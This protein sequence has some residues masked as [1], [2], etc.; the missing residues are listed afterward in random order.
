M[1]ISFEVLS[2]F[3]GNHHMFRTMLHS[4][5]TYREKCLSRRSGSRF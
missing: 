2:N 3:V 4:T 5:E 1:N